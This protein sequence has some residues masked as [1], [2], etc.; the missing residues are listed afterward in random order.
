M[1]GQAMYDF[2]GRIFPHFRSLTGEGVRITLREILSSFTVDGGGGQRFF[3]FLQGQKFLTG[4]CQKNG[5]S[6]RR[7]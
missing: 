5:E 4:Q 2:C 7:I 1:Q 6:L 3:L